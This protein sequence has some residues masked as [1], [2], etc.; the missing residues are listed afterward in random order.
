MGMSR[1]VI[2]IDIDEL[3]LDGFSADAVELPTSVAAQVSAA[4]VERGLPP[5]IAIST[6]TAVGAH[7]ARSIG[8]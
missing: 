6:A 3:V 5:A 2:R 8:A 1:D 4:L 7:V